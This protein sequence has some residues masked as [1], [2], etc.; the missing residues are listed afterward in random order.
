[1]ID[2]YLVNKNFEEI[3]SSQNNI[4]LFGS[5]GAGKTTL[6]NKICGI[7]LITKY[8]GFSC[9][10]DVQFGHSP[11][12]NIILDFLGLNAAEE[13]VKHLKIQRATLSIIP[14]RMI[15]LV[16]KLSVSEI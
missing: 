11:D 12:R 14:A 3:K 4:I 2:E 7:S 6:K 5:V 1:M 10:R 9:T 15:C 8:D 13:I 16:I